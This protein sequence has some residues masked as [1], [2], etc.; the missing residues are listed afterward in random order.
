MNLVAILILGCKYNYA[1]SFFVFPMFFLHFSWKK[2]RDSFDT[3]NLE[4]DLDLALFNIILFF[5]CFS[6]S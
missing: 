5:I 6:G 4:L 2:Q 1:F 3:L